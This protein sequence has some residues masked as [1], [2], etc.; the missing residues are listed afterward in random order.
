[1]DRT[2]RLIVNP[3]AGGGRALRALPAVEERLRGLGLEFRTD[4]TRDLDHARALAAESVAAGEVPVA[5]SG[6]GLVGAVAGVLAERPGSLMGILPGGRGN[7]F[8]RVLGLPLEPVAACDVLARGTPRPVDVGL[9]AGRPFIGI[10][11]LGFDSDANRIANEAPSFLGGLVYVYGALRAVLAWRPAT[12]TVAVDGAS[13]TFSGWSVAAA[14]S[15]AYGGGMFLAPDAELDDGRLDVVCTH[16]TGKL[17]FLRSLPKVFKGTHIGDPSVTVL[18]GAEV[19][20]AA[21]RP[22]TVYADGDP[23]AELPVTISTRPG[24]VLVLAPDGPAGPAGS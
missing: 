24:A 18:R 12:F 4:R 23:I 6:D 10:A 2:L 8:A 5:F 7:D 13:S 21:D 17:H 20:V 16:R 15:K 9:A 3:H 14:N 11:S 19:R 1:V 22:F